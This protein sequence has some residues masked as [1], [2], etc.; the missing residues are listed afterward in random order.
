MSVVKF[1]KQ[2][3]VATLTLDRPER[4]NALGASGDADDFVA[5]TAAINADRDIR[6]VILTGAGRAFCAG[7]DL[8]AMLDG[9]GMFG[10]TSLDL[11]DAY[12]Q[13]IQRI[14][15]SLHDIE[16]P[17]I[18]AVNGAAVGLGNDLLTLADIRIASSNAKFGATFVDVGLVP[19]DG[20]AWLLPRAIGWARAAELFFTGQL[21]DADTACQWGLISKVM[22][23]E[24]LLPAA[25]ALAQQISAKP[26]VAVRMTKQLLR[27]AQNNSFE[28]LLAM[29]ADMQAIAQRTQ[30]HM[31]ALRVKLHG[32]V[33]CYQ[34]R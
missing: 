7:G 3:H 18:A 29:S 4:L 33:E 13:N 25:L 11:R 2:D 32:Q 26:P 27:Q 31:T 10:G 28:T 5:A 16:V 23:P 9:T 34:G 6:C 14:V 15:R 21:I 19:G 17:L 12:R 20:G 1:E 22:P 30:D 8:K 24:A